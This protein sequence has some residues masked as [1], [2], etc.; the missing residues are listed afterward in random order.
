VR[1]LRGW[2]VRLAMPIAQ[3][4]KRSINKVSPKTLN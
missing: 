1:A 3:A 4:W 2:A